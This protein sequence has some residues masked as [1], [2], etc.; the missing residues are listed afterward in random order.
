VDIQ[1]LRT[2]EAADMRAQEEAKQKKGFFGRLFNREDK[3]LPPA[4]GT[5]VKK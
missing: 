5:N 4:P 1:A 2:S 3:K